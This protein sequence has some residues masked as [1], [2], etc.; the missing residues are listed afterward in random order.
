MVRISVTAIQ[1][2]DQAGASD[3]KPITPSDFKTTA[4][5][6]KKLKDKLIAANAYS[7]IVNNFPEAKVVSKDG[8]VLISVESSLSVENR[9][10]KKFSKL[11]KD[12]DGVKEVKTYVIPFET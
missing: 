7:L 11:I 2:Y 12:I 6:R 3:Y 5:T 1:V 10:S 4:E 9:L 8:V